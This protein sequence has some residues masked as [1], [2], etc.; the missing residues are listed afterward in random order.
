MTLP[1]AT[2]EASSNPNSYSFRVVANWSLSE[3][4]EGAGRTLDEWLALE[5]AAEAESSKALEEAAAGAAPEGTRREGRGAEL[6]FLTDSE[7]EI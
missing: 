6:I 2:V 4:R 7:A 3:K 5:R 1:E